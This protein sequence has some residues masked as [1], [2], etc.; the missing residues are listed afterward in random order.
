MADFEGL[1]RQALARQ[2]ASDPAV[3]EQ[4]YQASRNAFARMIAGAGPQPPHAIQYQKDALENCINRIEASYQPPPQPE[5]PPEPVSVE[6]EPVAPQPAPVQDDFASAPD[7]VAGEF[8]DG[9]EPFP[10]PDFAD[11]EFPETEEYLPEDENDLFLEEAAR[12]NSM[13]EG[14]GIR[15][16]LAIFAFLCLLLITGWLIYTLINMLSPGTVTQT[17]VDDPIPELIQNTQTEAEANTPFITILSP[18]DTEALETSGRGRAQIINQSNLDL[19]RLTSVRSRQNLA[20]SAQPI[21]INISPGVME[22]IA[23]RR[24]TVEIL[25]KSGGSGPATFSISCIFNNAEA[26]GRKRFRI[27]LQPEA[28]VFALNVPQESSA[29]EGAHFALNTDITGS[30]SITGQGDVV[31]ILYARLRLTDG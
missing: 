17:G 18:S 1:I 25:A 20:Q 2:D 31:D 6:P 26:C 12:A 24:V 3:R 21:L 22:Q 5:V 28:I 30:A 9:S 29:A 14:G 27:G 23:G 7:P 10:E 16:P 13:I 4:I 15:R 19:I 11:P 8:T